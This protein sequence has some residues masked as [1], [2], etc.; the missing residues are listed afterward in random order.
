MKKPFIT[1]DRAE[2]PANIP[3]IDVYKKCIE[4]LNGIVKMEKFLNSNVLPK[5]ISNDVSEVWIYY[6]DRGLIVRSVNE[7]LF[8]ALRTIRNKDVITYN[9]QRNFRNFAVGLLGC[10]VGFNIGSVMA[11][12]G[13]PKFM[14]IADFDRIEL[15]NLNRIPASICDIGQKKVEVLARRIW[16]IDPF[17]ELA[18]WDEL[19]DERNIDL[20][21]NQDFAIN[22][23]IDEVD[24]LQTK[25]LIRKKCKINKIPVLMATDNGDS[26]ILDVERFD[27]EPSRPIFHGLAGSI[28]ALD[29]GNLPKSDWLDLANKIIGE[30]FLTKRMQ[31]SLSNF[32]IT[33]FHIPQLGTASNAAGSVIAYAV[34]LLANNYNLLSGKYIIDIENI[35]KIP[36]K[37]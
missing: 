11:L 28:E 25:I 7:N 36:V 2:L 17:V 8:F 34:R 23:M 21:M 19:I 12:T 5:D 35:I 20:F 6:E 1:K 30:E 18:V 24:N 4:E 16:E 22:V 3:I 29:L 32:G 14:K 37:L 26:V 27:Q 9:E 33:T 15:T 13:G 10:S 31:K